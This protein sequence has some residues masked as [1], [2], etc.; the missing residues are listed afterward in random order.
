[1][2]IFNAD[3]WLFHSLEDQGRNHSRHHPA[4]LHF[5]PS[6]NSQKIQRIQ[7]GTSCTLVWFLSQ[8]SYG[9]SNPARNFGPIDGIKLKNDVFLKNTIVYLVM[10]TSIL[11]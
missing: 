5:S 10:V 7:W 11:C 4:R 9:C 2:E 1:M 3:F 6:A 8:V